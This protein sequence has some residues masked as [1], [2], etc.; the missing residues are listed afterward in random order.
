MGLPTYAAIVARLDVAGGRRSRRSFAAHT[1]FGSRLGFDDFFNRW[2]YN[3]LILLG[4][5]ACVLRTVRVR[6]ERGA[7]LALTIGVGLWAVA[8]LLFDF[9]YDGSPPY[10]VDRRRLLPRL[11]PRPATSR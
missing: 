5:L 3:A 6:A 8:E 9:A 11:L 2:L 4:S 7:W 1:L 10:S